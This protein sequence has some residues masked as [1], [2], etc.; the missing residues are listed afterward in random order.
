MSQFLDPTQDIIISLEQI[1]YRLLV[2]S[3]L[4]PGAA[5]LLGNLIRVSKVSKM[6]ERVMGGRRWRR[7]YVNGC[8]DSL[9]EAKVG[10]NF[11][12]LEFRFVVDL[13]FKSGGIMVIGRL[14][15]SEFF[16]VNSLNQPVFLVQTGILV[17]VM[18]LNLGLGRQLNSVYAMV[19]ILRQ[20]KLLLNP[21]HQLVQPSDRL[22]VI[23]RSQ[24]EADALAFIE[25]PRRSSMVKKQELSKSIVQNSAIQ[26]REA[27]Y[28]QLIDLS[29]VTVL[30]FVAY[31]RLGILLGREYCIA[32]LILVSFKHLNIVYLPVLK[33]S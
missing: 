8:K 20:R 2:L 7:A 16:G 27:N 18:V 33:S 14:L 26:T 29:L 23:A 19:G 28:G 31:W 9:F 24:Q 6:E 30:A 15:E 32:F 21:S 11:V 5:T 10:T 17:W 12:H 22:V 3:C 25:A 1:R 13:A 4:C